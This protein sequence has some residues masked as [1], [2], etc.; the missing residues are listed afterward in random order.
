MYS[1]EHIKANLNNGIDLSIEEACFVSEKMFEGS[2][3]DNQMKEV[4]VLLNKKNICSEEL[5]GFAT[6]MRK[7][8]T[9]VEVNEKVIDSCGTGGDGRY[10][11][12]INLCIFYC[13]CMRC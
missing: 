6:A 2:L 1:F 8:S 11:Q 10:V 9:K 4:L 5:I 13:S 12:Y 7:I 3:D